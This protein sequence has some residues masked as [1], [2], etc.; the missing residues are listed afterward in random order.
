MNTLHKKRF[1]HRAFMTRWA[2]PNSV[3]AWF[4]AILGLFAWGMIAPGDV[5]AC[6]GHYLTYRSQLE[7]GTVGLELLTSDPAA[8]VHPDEPPS[9]PPAPCFGAFCSGNPSHFPTTTQ[10]SPE[11]DH[12]LAISLTSPAFLFDET[13]SSRSGEARLVTVDRSLAIFHPPPSPPPH[14]VG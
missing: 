6:T 3:M 12:E 4:A 13:N 8:P 11:V 5:K 7:S 14:L 1:S 9:K 10:F 2:V